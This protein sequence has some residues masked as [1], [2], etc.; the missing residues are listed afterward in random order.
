MN[1]ELASF[2]Y[3]PGFEGDA[4]LSLALAV[5]VGSICREPVRSERRPSA[6]DFVN[7][8]D[9]VSIAAET[10]EQVAECLSATP[11]LLEL[12]SDVATQV[13]KVFGEG[14][15][16]FLWYLQDPEYPSD[17]N[18]I[19]YV[20]CE[21]DLSTALSLLDRFEDDWW[22]DNMNRAQGNLIVDVTVQ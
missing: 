9:S 10:F 20:R 14:K 22:L 8:P 15:Q 1:A 6:P 2:G 21:G 17:F 19:L 13:P 11:E 16:M 3:K 7:L 18:I 4:A 12:I 5:P